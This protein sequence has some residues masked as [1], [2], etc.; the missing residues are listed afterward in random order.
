MLGPA[1][2]G[3]LSCRETMPANPDARSAGLK[4]AI[5]PRRAARSAS[6]GPRRVPQLA[7]QILRQQA[8]IPGGDGDVLADHTLR[9]PSLLLN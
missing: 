3:R 6:R 9:G 8:P 7:K 4:T 2:T 1:S 5:G